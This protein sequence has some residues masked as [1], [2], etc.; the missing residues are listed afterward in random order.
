MATLRYRHDGPITLI[1]ASCLHYPIGDEG[2]LRK[3]VKRIRDDESA[4]TI[5]MGDMLDQDRTTHRKHRKAYVADR[6]SRLADDRHVDR[7]VDALAEILLP[8][9]DKIIGVLEGNHFY[10]YSTGITSDQKLCDKLGVPFLGAMGLVKL[11]IGG[12]GHRSALTIWAHHSGGSSGGR[13]VG[14]S[15]NALARQENAW[16]ADIYL[17]GHDHRRIAWRETT[18]R[19]N[20]GVT[21][22]VVERPKI[23]ARVGAFLKTHEHSGCVS[24][25]QPYFPHYGETAAYRPSDLG[26]VEIGIKLVKP[27]GAPWR[28]SYDLRTP[29]N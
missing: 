3:W 23:F 8:I 20:D 21:P 4:R 29:D 12:T 11:V 15:V 22:Q 7:D 1:P 14:G 16:D 13:T 10:E 19:L 18:L 5:L 9:N 6:N 2:L 26:W 27:A 25:K 24:T 28:V 17:V